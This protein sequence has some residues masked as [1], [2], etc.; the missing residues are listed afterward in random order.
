MNRITELIIDKTSKGYTHRE[1]SNFLRV[2]GYTP[3]SVS[4][5]EKTINSV[6]KEYKAKSTPHLIS[7]LYQKGHFKLKSS[8]SRELKKSTSILRNHQDWR[9]GKIDEPQNNPKDIGEAIDYI[10]NHLTKK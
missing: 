6:K 2:K 10:I 7:I 3:N 1:I 9:R 4:M 8:N 5:I